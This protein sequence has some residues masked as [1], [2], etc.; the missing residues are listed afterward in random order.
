MQTRTT[1]HQLLAIPLACIIFFFFLFAPEK[2][3]PLEG[4]LNVNTATVEEL[5]GLPFIGETR[6]RAIVEYRNTQ[7]PFDELDAI[8]LATDI[9]ESTYDAIKPYLK[10]SGAT[11][12]V[13]YK[14]TTDAPAQHN[15]TNNT[16]FAS[17]MLIM[18]KPG[19]IRVLAD[20]EY[21]NTLYNL[22]Q[23][24][25]KRID[26]AMFL[27]K[28]TDSPR[29]RPAMLLKKLIAAKRRGVDINVVLEESNYAEELTAENKKV[30]DKLRKKRIRVRFDAPDK[31]THTK[32]VVIDG[33]YSFVG[34]HNLSHMALAANHE[35]SLLIDS[36]PLAG[37]LTRY[38]GTLGKH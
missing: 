17:N 2:V 32:L 21:F 11:N 25:R 35:L 7:G 5:Q 36:Q 31:T 12:L 16:A 26:I 23:S 20:Q 18:T 3:W 34:S 29:N 30:A 27:F 37:E 8:L 4:E 15:S 14:N 38:I 19:D 9:G 6:A 24:A 10:L 13:G 33:R 22:V 28:T 1:A